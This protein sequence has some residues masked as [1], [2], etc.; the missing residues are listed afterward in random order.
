MSAKTSPIGVFSV[1]VLLACSFLGAGWVKA[2]DLPRLVID[3]QGHSG[4]VHEVIFSPDGKYLYSLG[5]DK[6]VRIWDV[7][8]GMLVDTI[9]SQIGESRD[10]LLFSGALSPDGKFLAIGGLIVEGLEMEGTLIQIINLE[11][12]SMAAVLEG[13][14]SSVVALDFSPDGN[15]L[16]SGGFSHELRIWDVRSVTNTSEEVEVALVLN[17]STLLRGHLGKVDGVAFSHDGKQLVSA[18]ADK[19][20]ILWRRER[21][22]SAFY[23]YHILKRHTEGIKAAAYSSDGKFIAT[24]GYDG[25]LILWDGKEGELVKILDEIEATSFVSVGFSPEGDEV[26]ASTIGGGHDYTYFYDIKTGERGNR[27]LNYRSTVMSVAWS[28]DGELIATGGGTSTEVGLWQARD[29]QSSGRSRGSL[30]HRLRGDGDAIWG[31][32]FAKDDPSRLAYGQTMN[33]E[34]FDNGGTL[35]RV[36]DFANFELSDIDMNSD[37]EGYKGAFRDDG[38]RTLSSVDSHTLQI[39]DSEKLAIDSYSNGSIHS[40]SFVPDHKRIL[41]GSCF[42]LELFEKVKGEY[43]NSIDYEGI[44]DDVWGISPSSDGK[45]VAAGSQDQTIRLWNLET[46]E[47]LVSLFVSPGGEW[48]CWTRSGYYHASP[49]GERYIGWHFNRGMHKLGEFFPSYVFREQFHHPEL[50]RQTVLLGSY[51][52]AIKEVGVKKVVV[53]EVLPPRIDWV[54]PRI[55]RGDHSDRKVLV[56]AEINSPN[57]ALEEVKLLLNG[58]TIKSEIH[59]DGNSHTFEEGILLEPGENRLTVFARNEHAGHLSSERILEVPEALV[60]VP[61]LSPQLDQLDPES[62][63]KPNLY[64]LVV[65]VS[66]YANPN[67][68]SLNFC[69]EDAEAIASLFEGQGG[70]LFANVEIRL[71]LDQDASENGIQAGLD[72]LE[73]SA[74]QKDFVVLFLAAH[75]LNDAKGNF[76]L[77]PHDADPEQL[78]S[79]GVA[80]DDFG[81]ILGNLPSRVLMFLDTC[82]SGR[83]GAN[84]FALANHGKGARTR[85]L[86][87]KSVF[88]NSEAIRELTSDENGVVIMAASTGNE[89][90]IEHED[91]EHG[92]FTLGILEG[93]R[94]A[95]DINSDGVIHLRE[96]DFFVSDRVKALTGGAQHPTTVKPSTL[97]RLPVAAYR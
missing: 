65:G 28:E 4:K 7:E 94:G 91:W 67:I 64:A 44:T 42:A 83:L 87:L 75:G 53:A 43:V 68:P 51:E 63:L 12:G 6:T 60:P 41:V 21:S 61:N 70:G 33:S 19:T 39:G 90:S 95:A 14:S 38:N 11:S 62:L 10:G 57:G 29:N 76:Y 46:G 92:A 1:G 34:N 27:G 77:L 32:A 78:R 50:V 86:G 85:S 84:L 47:P 35:E 56:K 66:D 55:A 80:W 23:K 71:L 5:L 2:E 52:D 9:R 17:R 31:V 97:S 25:R 72:W 37:S 30:V 8:S 16:A 69:D 20:A 36:F 81:D 54:F 88:D 89:E 73:V 13:H 49:G 40:V 15:W 82:H 3:P 79:T 59:L 24:A 18:S 58:K 26:V 22:D 96:L 45:Y 93:L 48:V 74:T